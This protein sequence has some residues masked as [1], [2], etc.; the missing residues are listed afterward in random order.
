MFL[1]ATVPIGV[2]IALA[3]GLLATLPLLLLVVPILVLGRPIGV[4]TLDRIREQLS[5]RDSRRRPTSSR[6]PRRSGFDL[7]TPRTGLLLAN[8]LAERGPPPHLLSA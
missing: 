1:L 2:A 3:G 6:Q 8:S 7:F 4:E 5:Q